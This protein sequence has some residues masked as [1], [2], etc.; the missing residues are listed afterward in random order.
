M[1][2]L[3]IAA[4]ILVILLWGA[5]SASADSPTDNPAAPTRSAAPSRSTEAQDANPANDVKPSGAQ[6]LPLPPP[7]AST[8]RGQERGNAALR[9]GQNPSQGGSANENGSSTHEK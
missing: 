7:D 2:R 4:A 5:A 9:A 3:P 1:S 6:V 8:A